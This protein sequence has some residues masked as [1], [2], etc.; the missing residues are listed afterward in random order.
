MTTAPPS[1]SALLTFVADDRLVGYIETANQPCHRFMRHTV[2]A[3]PVCGKSWGL[4][5]RSTAHL[6]DFVERKCEQHGDGSLIPN[7]L[8]RSPYL[9]RHIPK[10]VIERELL[11][12]QPPKK[13]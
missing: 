2:F 11:I 7:N 5:M 4:I 9:Y 3:C 10:P 13:P 1:P 8:W 6:Y 12:W